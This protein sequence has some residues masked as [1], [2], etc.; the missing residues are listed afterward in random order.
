[1]KQYCLLPPT[2]YRMWLESPMNETINLGQQSV[3]VEAG[4][5]SGQEERYEAN[6]GQ[7]M[8]IDNSVE[9]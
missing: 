2:T 1:M 7:Q 4:L 3:C 5:G 6:Q 9:D 8:P